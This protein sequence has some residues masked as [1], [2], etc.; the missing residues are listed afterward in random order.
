MAAIHSILV[1]CVGN[2]CRSPVGERLLARSLP[3]ADIGSAG[4]GAVVGASADE[5]MIQVANENDLSLEGHIARQ[6]TPEMG[7]RYELILVMEAG[8]RAEIAR[9]AP[10]LSGRVMLFDQWTGACG[11]PDPYREPIETHRAA[12]QTIEAAAQGWIRR[13]APNSMKA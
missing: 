3:E 5:A 11:I 8:H 9:Q 10:H 2:I 6:F 12:Y 13:I 4:I 7:A 1:V